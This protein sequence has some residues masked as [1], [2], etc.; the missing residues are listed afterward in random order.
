MILRIRLQSYQVHLTMLQYYTCMQYTVRHVQIHANPDA[1]MSDWSH[2][3]KNPSTQSW[4]SDY[5]QICSCSRTINVVMAFK[6]FNVHSVNHPLC[7]CVHRHYTLAKKSQHDE[8]IS[9]ENTADCQHWD[10]AYL[11]QGRLTSVTI[12]IHDTDRQQNF[13]ICSLAH[14]LTFPEN[15]TQIRLEVFSQSR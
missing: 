14:C 8:I 3:Y 12:R 1:Y 7:I 11:H 10:S 2:G 9:A 4:Y 5:L 15:F 13:I 6:E